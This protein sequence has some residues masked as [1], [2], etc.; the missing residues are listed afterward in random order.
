M[1]ASLHSLHIYPVKSLG[2]IDVHQSVLTAEGLRHDRRWVITDEKG[3]F[4]TQ[5]GCARMATLVPA[6]DEY[7][8]ILQSPDRR[9]LYIPLAPPQASPSRVRIFG[10]ECRGLD[11]GDEA[12]HWLSAFL[13]RPVRLKRVPRDNQRRV[14]PERLGDHVAHTGFADGYP[15][16][17]A[18]LS[19][20]AALNER[21]ATQGLPALPM[22]R[23]RPNIVIEGAPPFAEHGMTRLEGEN[24][25]LWLCKPCERCRIT[26]INQCSGDIAVPGEPLKTLM[27]MDHVSAGRAFFG[28]NAVVMQGDGQSLYTKMALRM[29]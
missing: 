12:A 22:S 28:E 20:L 8:L 26:T 15:L 25:S 2:G 13:E 18:S 29:R 10:N 6:I 11:E 1:S 19:S 21:L 3:D 17:V 5:R 14:S 23:F 4:I 9:H 7:H 24:L 27:A 16:L